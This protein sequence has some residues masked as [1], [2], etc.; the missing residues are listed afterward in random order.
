MDD[1]FL[2]MVPTMLVFGL[3]LAFML[4]QVVNDGGERYQYKEYRLDEEVERQNRKRGDGGRPKG[5]I[6]PN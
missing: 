5:P 3:G 1:I 6:S 2:V 4:R